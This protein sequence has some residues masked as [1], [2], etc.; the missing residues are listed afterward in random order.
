VALADDIKFAI[1]EE[2]IPLRVFTP[3]PTAWRSTRR[4]SSRT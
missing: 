4:S 2:I 3:A 1:N